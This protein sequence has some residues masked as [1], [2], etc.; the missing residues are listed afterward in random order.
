MVRI[1][2]R[3]PAKRPKTNALLTLRRHRLPGACLFSA[4]ISSADPNQRHRLC[5]SFASRR[6]EDSKRDDDFDAVRLE[7]IEPGGHTG[8]CAQF[9]SRADALVA[10][11]V[12]QLVAGRFGALNGGAPRR[13]SCHRAL[14]SMGGHPADIQSDGVWDFLYSPQHR[15]LGDGC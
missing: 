14:S 13:L 8:P 12:H 9:L 11:L 10:L 7:T 2:S 3:P 6:R 15:R 4:C 1:H 5:G